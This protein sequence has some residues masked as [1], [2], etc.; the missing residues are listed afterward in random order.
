[1]HALLKKDR[2][3]I[4]GAFGAMGRVTSRADLPD[5][6]TMLR[7]VR[8][9]AEFLAA[10]RSKM[11]RRAKPKPALPSPADL[12]TALAG[13]AAAAGAWKKFSPAMRRDYIEWITEAK[14][15]E[16]RTTRIATTV[17]W[18]AEGKKRNWRYE[19]C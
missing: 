2:G 6:A 9:A 8:T 5:D 4:E 10:G 17:A 12:V 15:A 19:E 7:Y 18:V 16:T 3:S 14:R 13:N 11:V 1:M